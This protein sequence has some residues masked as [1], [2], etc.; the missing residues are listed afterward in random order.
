[1]DALSELD[2]WR[3]SKDLAVS[4]YKNLS[5]CADRGFRDQVTR[6]AVSI[7]SNIAEGYERASRK[8][9]ARFLLIAKGSCAE[10]RTQ[11]QIGREI[12]YFNREI[13]DGMLQE[14]FA[15]TKMMQGLIKRC[16]STS[17]N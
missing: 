3:R 15:I 10:L 6:S 17:N 11:I 5:G 1:M 14:A 13:A 12:G 8:E 9:F 4:V 16:K 7:P 2:V